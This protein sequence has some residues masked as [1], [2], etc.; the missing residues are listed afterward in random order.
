MKGHKKFQYVTL[1][2]EMLLPEV[3]YKMDEALNEYRKLAD[4]L[5]RIMVKHGIREGG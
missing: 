5:K 4:D 2:E 1:K 3:K